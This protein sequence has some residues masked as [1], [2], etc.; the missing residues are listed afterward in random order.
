MT[1]RIYFKL[2]LSVF[3]VL[4]VAMIAVDVL[5]T[6]VVESSYI[7]NLRSELSSKA[8]VIG[9]SFSEAVDPPSIERAQRMAR[10][11]HLRLTV[12]ERDGRV[13]L[14]THF[15]PS[16]MQNHAQR[17]EFIEA[18]RGRTG[19]SIRQSA[20][21][22]ES[23]LY[24]AIPFSAGALRLAVP[25]A[26]VNVQVNAIRRRMLG[27]AALAFLPAILITALVARR[28]STKLGKIIG[29]ASELA[30]G[31]FR[32][33][34]AGMGRGELGILSQRLNE[35]SEHLQ[36]A[37][38]QLEREHAE[39]ERV[40]RVRKDFVINV[41]HELRT[42]LASIQGYA[43]TLLDGAI[44]D[45]E[46]NMR[47]LGIIRQNAERLA[48]LTADLLTISRIEM[49]RQDLHF[50]S[51]AVRDILDEAID[52]IKPVA[53][54]KQLRVDLR[55]GLEHD[56]VHC[57]SEAVHQILINLLDNAI[58]YTPEGGAITIGAR[59]HQASGS[60]PMTAIYVR[61]TGMG[62][63]AEDVPR[64]FERFYRVDKAR[65]RELGGT[66]LGLAIVKHLVRAQG[67]D[68]WVES[69]LGRGSTFF[70]TLSSTV[71]DRVTSP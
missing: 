3:C 47:F 52:T 59:P 54:K 49:K 14:E 39:L 25:L 53:Q 20:T 31:N 37:V 35:A 21:T 13:L 66:G 63:P 16:Q 12:I 67:G 28:T 50:G 57:D 69:D 46:N 1:A 42:P 29:F 17:A 68:V 45:R 51:Y 27:A 8:R 43:E 33:R 10:E 38:E 62:I 55:I 7:D 41:S 70:F 5:A 24:V 71:Y 60:E 32:A 22:G 2:I 9:I 36:R 30:K 4:A 56:A 6:R 65:S 48:S 18:L 34:L 61:D 11:A 15:D 58:K 19:W 64:L 26:D 23:Y 40:E 44:E